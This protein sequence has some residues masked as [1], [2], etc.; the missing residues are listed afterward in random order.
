MT[1]STRAALAVLVAA[2]GAGAA[3]AAPPPGS[4]RRVDVS[5]AAE[6]GANARRGFSATTTV[7]LTFTLSFKDKTAAGHVAQLRLFTPDGNL[8]RAM[9][10][11]IAAPNAAR[12]RRTVAGYPR[13]LAEQP[14]RARGSGSAIRYEVDFAFPVDTS[15]LP[16]FRLL[17][18]PKADKRLVHWDGGHYTSDPLV[19]RETLAWFD[20]YV[21]PGRATRD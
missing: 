1:G 7:D 19:I 11:P 5:S 10:Q 13:P 12:G 6:P 9:A 15:Q 8:Y 4:C 2:A 3:L 20:R 18:A 21:K 16:M 17:G 14:L